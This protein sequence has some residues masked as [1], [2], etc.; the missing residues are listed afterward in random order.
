MFHFD[1]T[2]AELHQ[3]LSGAAVTLCVAVLGAVF[4]IGVGLGL[5][6]LRNGRWVPMRWI[7]LTYLSFVRGTPLLVQIFLIYYA[8]PG[9]IGIDVPA[10]PAGVIALSLNSGAFM[11]EIL[12][13]GLSAI[14]RNQLE[15]AQALG[16]SRFDVWSRVILPQLARLVLP[17]MVNE[18]AMLVHAS[19]LLSV[20]AIVDLMR[21]AQ[22]VMNTTH[23]PV[24][25]L[26]V[27]AVIYFVALFALGHGVRALE[28]HAT[29]KRS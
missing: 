13:G 23:Q 17:P 25:A 11:S 19:A 15:A 16:L 29:V 14:P 1:A 20:I 26:A 4:G 5:L 8:L 9:L 21:A 22:N 3:F 7:A 2:F 6:F 12:R 27:A 24:E 10:F 28:R 18:L